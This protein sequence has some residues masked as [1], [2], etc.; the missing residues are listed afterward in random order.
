M[1]RKK[2]TICKANKVIE[3]GYRLSLNEQRLILACVGQ[4]DSMKPLA[5]TDRFELTAKEFSKLY[6]VTEDKVYQTLKEVSEQLF[7]RYVIID[8]PDP[9]E[10]TLKYTK[11]RWVSS[12]DYIPEKGKIALYFAAR[13]LPY[14]SLLQ[15]QFTQYKLEHIGKMTSIYAIRLYE[16]LM[17]WQ[18]VGKRE[19]ELTWLKQQFELDESYGR[20]DNFKARV[21]DPAVKDINTHSNYQISWTQR[22]T[23]RNV[24][25]LMFTF[26]EKPQPQAKPKIKEKMINGVKESEIAKLAKIGESWEGAAAR[27]KAEKQAA[28]FR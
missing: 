8:N 2:L 12:I 11:T 1:K 19:V 25:H 18:N 26:F 28:K 17:Q 15:G 3:A 5:I 24:T 21:L 13:M 9:D 4:I 22:K 23:G 7:E 27:I 20:M 16:L 6:G 14:L 10:P